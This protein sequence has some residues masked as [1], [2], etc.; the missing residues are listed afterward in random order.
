MNCSNIEGS[1]GLD[2]ENAKNPKKERVPKKIHR[3]Q[4][5]NILT[6]GNSRGKKNGIRK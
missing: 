1:G 3:K 2:S 6:V 5:N 4:K